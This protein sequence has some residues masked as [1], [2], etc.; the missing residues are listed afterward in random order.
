MCLSSCSSKYRVRRR[1][2]R[3]TEI[4]ARKLNRPSRIPTAQRLLRHR[5]PWKV[6]ILNPNKEMP[7]AE[8]EGNGYIGILEIPALALSLPVMSKWSYPKLK[9]APCRYSGSAY[10]GNLVIAAHNYRTHF[11]LLESLEPGAQVKFTDVEGNVFSYEIAE[12]EILEPTA[13]EELLSD[14]WNLTLFTCTYGGQARVAVRCR[15]IGL[16]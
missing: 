13:I 4:R 9:I 12:T 10:T 16:K 3:Q 6:H 11:G 14:E 5:P 2:L 8:I 15:A 1:L 7:E